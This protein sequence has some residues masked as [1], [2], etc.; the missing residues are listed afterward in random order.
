[1]HDCPGCRVPLHGYEEVCPSCGTRQPRRKSRSFSNF[2]PEN[3][4]INWIPVVVIFMALLVLLGFGMSGSWISKLV[5]EGPVKE[6]PMDKL[7]Y[8]E[9]RNFVEQELLSGFAAAGASAKLS[10]TDSNLGKAV[11]KS[12]DS[13]VNLTVDTSL[14]DPNARK[15]IVEKV[16][17]YMEKAKIPTLTI[18][19]SKTHAHW[20]YNMSQPVSAPSPEG[21]AG[22]N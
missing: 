12:T 5:T 21:E 6:N 14:P 1:M 11:D 4:G 13:S 22:V 3:P 8:I 18:N 20:T 2:R 19:D 9:A 15:S 17:D 7:T 10:W 16:K